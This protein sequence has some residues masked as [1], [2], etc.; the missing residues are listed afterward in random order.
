MASSLALADARAVVARA[1]SRP[2]APRRDVFRRGGSAVAVRPR[3][4]NRHR[5][6]DDSASSETSP[7]SSS[8]C[9][10]LKDRRSPR[11]RGRMGTSHLGFPVS[12]S[13]L[14]PRGALA[15]AGATP[16]DDDDD[17]AAAAE[18]T[19]DAVVRVQREALAA[20]TALRLRELRAE[21]GRERAL[22]D[23]AR[24]SGA[25]YL[26]P[27]PVRPRR[28]GERRSLRT[29]PPPLPRPRPRR[30]ITSSSSLPP[31]RRRLGIRSTSSSRKSPRPRRTRRRGT[32][33]SR[34]TPPRTRARSSSTSPRRWR[35]RVLLLLSHR[36]PYDRVG[37]VN[38]VP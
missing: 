34:R 7:S 32:T 38:A 20:E 33:G 12:S 37:A 17:D 25:F 5:R 23:R 29:L 19:R 10:V 28:R 8:S 6:G 1:R 24:E 9:E 13:S 36:S 11:E 27:V 21:R 18:T 35:R 15:P 26:T 30:V 4:K 16:D 2:F 14:P 31:R 3:A 22:V